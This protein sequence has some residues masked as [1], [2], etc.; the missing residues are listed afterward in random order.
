MTHCKIV[1]PVF[2]R[3]SALIDRAA[4]QNESP[5]KTKKPKIRKERKEYAKRDYNQW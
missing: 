3:H 4:I 1:G 5:G 2:P